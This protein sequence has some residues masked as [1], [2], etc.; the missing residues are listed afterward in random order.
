MRAQTADYCSACHKV[1][2]DVPVNNYRWTRGFNDYDKLASERS[3]RYG[4]SVFLLPAETAGLRRL[5]HVA[6]A[7]RRMRA[8]SMAPFIPIAS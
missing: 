2:L 1:H 6:G 3:F 5:S 4:R 8:T 7:L